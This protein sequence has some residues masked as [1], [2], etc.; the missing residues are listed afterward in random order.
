MTTTNTAATARETIV[1]TCPDRTAATVLN[2][3]LRT[4]RKE[5]RAMISNAWTDAQGRTCATNGY[6]AIC[7]P[8]RPAALLPDVELSEEDKDRA[9]YVANGIEE[10]IFSAVDLV[11]IQAPDLAAVKDFYA[12]HKS[13]KTALERAFDL[14]AKL[15]AVD[16]V[17]L[18]NVFRALPSASWYV[19]PAR[20]IVSPLYAMDDETGARAVILPIRKAAA[21][22]EPAAEAETTAQ[23]PEPVADPE[24][25]R[26][27]E[28][29]AEPE[30]AAQQ[31]EPVA[32]PEPS[33][34]EAA[35]AE[36]EPARIGTS[37]PRYTLRRI[38]S[39]YF[40]GLITLAEAEHLAKLAGLDAEH[41]MEAMAPYNPRRAAQQPEPAT[42]E[43]AP[44]PA[45]VDL[46]N[47]WTVDAAP[48]EPSAVE[49]A[50]VEPAAVEPAADLSKPWAGSELRGAW[51]VIRFDAAT[52]R[53]RLTLTHEPSEKA[54]A[55]IAEAGF[56]AS[57]TAPGT[58]TRKL[59]AKAY[60]AALALAAN[61]SYFHR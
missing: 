6:M 3:I 49:P 54:A 57:K 11:T 33:A 34:A 51:W 28:P 4:S 5:G 45:A 15:P 17:Y 24:P 50:A 26:E 44:A 10:K 21:D 22:P 36:E 40:S 31:P 43:P 46:G 55:Y 30:T 29:S 20:S 7:L 32:D 61:L 48:V 58:Y 42:E 25:T 13:G 35:P 12:Q 19:D 8:W 9:A 52:A 37:F 23:D 56:W 27:P 2:G 16:I 1:K 14:G 18:Y 38:A 47:G 41:I 53:T 59:T 39:R 60:R